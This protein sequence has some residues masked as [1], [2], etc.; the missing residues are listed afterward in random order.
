MIETRNPYIKILEESEVEKVHRL[1]CE[2][3]QWLEGAEHSYTEEERNRCL[4]E[5]R[6]ISKALEQL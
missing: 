5:L 1:L 3:N 2:A 6:K 4:E